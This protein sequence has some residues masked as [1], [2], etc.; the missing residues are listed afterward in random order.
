MAWRVV[1]NTAVA[2]VKGDRLNSKHM[3]LVMPP[4]LFEQARERFAADGLSFSAGVRQLLTRY[5]RG[6]S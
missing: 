4:S 2:P 6:E 5:L 3:Q 1:D